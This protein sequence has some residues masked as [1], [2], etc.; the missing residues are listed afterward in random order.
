VWFNSAI[1]VNTLLFSVL[2]YFPWQ[3]RARCTWI[4]VPI[5][6][7]NFWALGASKTVVGNTILKADGSTI[8]FRFRSFCGRHFPRIC[9]F[10]ISN[11]RHEI[12][13]N[14][15]MS[16]CILFV[17]HFLP[18]FY[19]FLSPFRAEFLYFFPSHDALFA[20]LMVRS[21]P[22]TQ[23]FRNHTDL[24]QVTE[25]VLYSRSFRPNII[26]VAVS[27]CALYFMNFEHNWTEFEKNRISG[28]HE[29]YFPCLESLFHWVGGLNGNALIFSVRNLAE[30]GFPI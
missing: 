19:F 22:S 11:M 25:N 30:N 20:R 23:T 9:S 5:K 4:K 29:I 17:F 14:S 10:L 1:Q 15:W 3:Q 16:F 26:T 6:I 7:R 21:Y 12:R 28:C 8:M 2:F 24:N 13:R 18:S 27:L